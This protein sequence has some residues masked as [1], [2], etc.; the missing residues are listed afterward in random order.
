MV[1]EN[2]SFFNNKDILDEEYI[3][4]FRSLSLSPLSGEAFINSLIKAPF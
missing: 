1:E 2:E 3:T 4:G